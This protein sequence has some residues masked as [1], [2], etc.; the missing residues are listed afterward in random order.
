MPRTYTLT[1]D[2]VT[3]ESREDGDYSDTGFGDG[4]SLNTTSMST[5]DAAGP[6]W[7]DAWCA[8][9]DAARNA[10]TDTIEPDEYDLDD[11]DGDESAAA[12]ALMV[13]LIV[14]HYGATEPSNSSGGPG[15]WYTEA[16]GSTD[17]RTGEVTRVSVHLAG[18]TPAEQAA[19][20][21][22]VTGR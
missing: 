8:S 17:Y 9:H 14:R 1:Y 4:H 22:A 13:A 7:S 21:R 5:I 20:Y 10:A 12:V 18:W 19:I 3:H 2:C 11:H 16:D 15:T 6:H